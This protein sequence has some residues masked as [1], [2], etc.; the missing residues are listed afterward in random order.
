MVLPQV[1]TPLEHVFRKLPQE[2]IYEA[3]RQRPY[4]FE[5]GAFT[6]PR[7]MAFLLVE[8]GFLVY[9]Q[10]GAVTGDAVPVEDRRLSLQVGYDVNIDRFQAGNVEVQIIPV[11]PSEIDRMAAQG[12]VT[13]PT[14]DFQPP[15]VTFPQTV[16]NGVV[17]PNV[18]GAPGS[19][20]TGAP[21]VGWEV[22]DARSHVDASGVGSALL[23]Q[24]SNIQGPSQFPFTFVLKANQSVQMRISVFS[25][26]RIPVAFFES[27]ILGYVVPKNSIEGL[28]KGINPCW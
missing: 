13:P 15:Q 22:Q 8:Y 18:Y 12:V 14:V 1:F 2:G 7:S 19:Q 24:E 10:N 27:R 9:R 21:Q 17:L 23:P 11:L 26:V 3:T 5:M 25:P 6:V 20:A 16:V 4:Q 28:L